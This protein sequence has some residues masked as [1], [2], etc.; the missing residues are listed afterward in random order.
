MLFETLK[1]TLYAGVGLAFFTKDKLEEMGKRMAEE[2]KL[3]E[4]DAKKFIDEVL[5]KSEDAKDAFE[6]AVGS[7]VKATLERLDIPRRAELKAL[8]DRVQALE[9]RSKTP[10]SRTAGS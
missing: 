10:E 3:N 5:R 6:K 4:E 1:K 7:G 2:A 8:E 9:S